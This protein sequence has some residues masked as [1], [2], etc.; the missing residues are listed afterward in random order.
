MMKAV[1]LASN[2]GGRI[3]R[4][5]WLSDS[6]GNADGL[7]ELRGLCVRATTVPSGSVAPTANYDV[8]FYDGNEQDAFGGLLANRSATAVETVNPYRSDTTDA[9]VGDVFLSGYYRVAV[10][11]AGSAKRGSVYLV[12]LDPVA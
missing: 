12:L 3:V 9:D 1:E 4:L 6:S 11:N 2:P 5:D 8:A 10:N 7:V